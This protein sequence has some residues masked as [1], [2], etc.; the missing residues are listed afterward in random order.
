MGLNVDALRDSFE[1]VI[2]RE[3]TVTKRFYEI[4]FERYPR[5]KPLFNQVRIAEQQ[6]MLAAALTAVLDH[7]EDAPWLSHHLAGLGARHVVYGVTPLMYD[8]VGECLV[9]TLAEAA[10]DEWSRDYEVAWVEAFGAIRNLMLAGAAEWEK[11]DT[12]PEHA[13]P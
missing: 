12:S 9:A 3:P 10:G 13:R 1:L 11:I 2:E 4:L 5:V 7:L 6:K 8:Y